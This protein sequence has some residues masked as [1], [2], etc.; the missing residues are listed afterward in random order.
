MLPNLFENN[1]ITNHKQSSPEFAELQ[2]LTHIFLYLPP[3][4]ILVA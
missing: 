3:L 4:K 2:T 1:H